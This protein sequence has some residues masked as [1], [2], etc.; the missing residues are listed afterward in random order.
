MNFLE[1]KTDLRDE[2][3]NPTTTDVTDAK[4]GKYIN[5]AYRDIATQ[6]RHHNARS[7]C[8]FDTIGSA[9][10]YAL[11]ASCGVLRTIRNVTKGYKL[12][13]YDAVEV[14]SKGLEVAEG[15]PTHYS[16]NQDYIELYPTPESTEIIELYYEQLIVDLS[17][18][19]DV[20]VL[21]V[22][23]HVGIVKLARWY[24]F[25]GLRS[26][27]EAKLAK[28]SF[29]EWAS[30]KISEFDQEKSDSD[31]G[32]DVGFG[33]TSPTRLDFSHEDD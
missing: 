15:S 4:L 21:L 22:G 31:I 13:K 33:A 7:Y 2:C 11:P 20:P 5:Y 8:R 16:R 18:D 14:A 12:R 27:T 28:D 10:R 9:S 1:L 30:N 24:Y 17:D 29:L 23:W 19:L 6:Y 3:G 26:Y 32:V 25:D